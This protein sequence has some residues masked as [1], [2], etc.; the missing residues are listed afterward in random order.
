MEYTT[1]APKGAAFL[2]EERPGWANEINPAEMDLENGNTCILGQ[3]YGGNWGSYVTGVEKL[4][5]TNPVGSMEAHDWALQHGFHTKIKQD[6][7]WVNHVDPTILKAEW[8]ALITER[9]SA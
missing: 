7:E 5:G 4:F 3:L 1:N 6:V 2:D 9:K 8:T